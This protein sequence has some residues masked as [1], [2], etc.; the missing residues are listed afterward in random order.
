MGCILKSELLL[1]QQEGH[2]TVMHE[3]GHKPENYFL[4]ATFMQYDK[5]HYLLDF[6]QK[7]LELAADNF[8]SLKR[9][10]TNLLA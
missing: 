10:L 7:H 9:S 6:S 8:A 5:D 4:S 3:S 2:E 1:S